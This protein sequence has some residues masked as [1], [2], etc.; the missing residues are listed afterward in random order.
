MSEPTVEQLR[1]ALSRHASGA[2]EVFPSTLELIAAEEHW[3]GR[4]WDV[5][6]LIASDLERMRYVAGGGRPDEIAECAGRWAESGLSLD[7]IALVI[8]AG[9]YDPDPFVI[10]AEA[11]LLLP[12]LHNDDGSERLVGGER[13]GAWISDE[14]ALLAP[15][16]TVE[17]AR[18]IIGDK[19]TTAPQP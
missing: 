18:G 11:G 3:S 12:A 1:A 10:L 19:T 16:E 4:L 2:G 17:R 8:G 9:G 7:D 15:E 13:A 14:L 5:V 6:R